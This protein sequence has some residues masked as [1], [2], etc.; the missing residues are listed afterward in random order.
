MNAG[1]PLLT[2]AERWTCK[3]GPLWPPLLCGPGTSASQRGAATEGRPYRSIKPLQVHQTSMTDYQVHDCE[4]KSV[5][6]VT[7]GCGRNYYGL[8]LTLASGHLLAT[9]AWY[10]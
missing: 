9:H 6:Q 4:V 8:E 7:K 1:V 5:F 2:R 3:C 10:C